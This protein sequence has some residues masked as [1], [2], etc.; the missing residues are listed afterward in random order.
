M[1]PKVDI[2]ATSIDSFEKIE[3]SSGHRGLSG[4]EGLWTAMRRIFSATKHKRW[5]ILLTSALIVALCVF[6]NRAQL[7]R[8][9]IAYKIYHAQIFTPPPM[10]TE[11]AWRRFTESVQFYRDFADFVM[12][13]NQRLKQLKPVLNPL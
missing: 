10:A 8:A 7:M 3:F 1:N 5:L 12:A 9:V 11:S 13:R 6:I 4:D 2:H